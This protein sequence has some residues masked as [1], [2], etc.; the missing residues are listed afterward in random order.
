MWVSGTTIPTGRLCAVRDGSVQCHGEDGSFGR[1]VGS[2]HQS[3]GHVWAAAE[4]GLWRWAPGAPARHAVRGGPRSGLQVLT[5]DGTGALLVQAGAGIG[6]LAGGSERP[7]PLPALRPSTVPICLFRD[8]DGGL[9]IGTDGGLL[10]MREGRTDV[11]TRSD[12]LSGDTVVRIFEDREGSIWVATTGGLDRFR[13]FAAVR[14]SAGQDVP[15]G[16]VASVLAAREGGVLLTTVT[17]GLYRWNAGRVAAHPDRALTRRGVSSLFQ[18]RRGRIWVGAPDGVGYL[19]GDRFVPIRGVPGGLVNAIVEDA[20]GDLWVAHWTLGLYRV[21]TRGEVRQL[22]WSTFGRQ[23][24]AS[25]LVADPAQG[26][27]WLGFTLGGLAYFSGGKVQASYTA[28][29]GLARGRV[30]DLRIDESGALWAATEGGLSRLKDGRIVTLTARSGLPCDT[31]YAILEDDARATWLYMSCG[32]VRIARADLDAW[33]VAAG[34]DAKPVQPVRVMVLDNADGVRNTDVVSSYSPHATRASD[35]RLWLASSDGVTVIDPAH[36]VVN[37]LPPPVRIE[38]IVADRQSY[39]MASVEGSVR[40]PPVSD[41]QMDYTALSF[42]APEKMRFRYRLDGWDRDWQEAGTRR[43]AF[44]TNLG[45]G[46]YR[47]RVS[48]SNNSGVWNEAGAAVDFS[49]APVFYQT[50]WFLVLSMGLMFAA[51]WVAHRIRLRIVETHEHEISALNERLMKA[52][53]QERIRIAGELHDGVAQEMLAVTMMLGTAKRRLPDDS[54]AKAAIDKIQQKVIQ[55]GTDIRQIS[56]DLHPPVL[57][58]A[59]LPEAVRAYCEEFAAS[60]G[61]A[62]RCEAD[63]KVSDLSRGAGL[64]LFRILQEALGNAAKHAAP[65]QIKVRLTRFRKMV[66][67]TVE[68]DGAGF[69]R[70]RLEGSSGLGLI[71]MRERAGQLNGLFEVDSVAGR[72]TRVR[73]EIPFR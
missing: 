34:N 8:R 44:Y 39:P 16:I 58:E 70:S 52:Q 10:H 50:P 25:R 1:W 19:D 9:W 45:P 15:E 42:V 22:P 4:S 33:V 26:G 17:R 63:D 53:E 6:R 61:I 36:L 41:L 59:G 37:T 54:D 23:D 56:H 27:I 21:G 7:V 72:G 69:D 13:E 35:G 60:S 68:D 2:L 47:F 43:Q 18:D 62:V 49:I 73:V 55:V 71:S 12:G 67:L 66:F 5:G 51:I 3:D 65:K 38:Q 46:S 57:Q 14:L 48:A 20:Q 64:A 40:L 28:G 32:I 30:Y 24:P 31:A 29:D 11:F